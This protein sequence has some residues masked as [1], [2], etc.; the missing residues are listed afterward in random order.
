MRRDIIVSGVIAV[1][2]HGLIFSLPLTMARNNYIGA[3]HHKSLS[4]S[5]IY[6]RKAVAALPSVQ[7]PQV[8]SK[9]SSE[10]ES[11]TSE[12]QIVIKK[13]KVTHKK[14]FILKEMRVE[15]G[16]L[17]EA[18]QPEPAPSQIPKDRGK[19]IESTLPVKTASAGGHIPTTGQGGIE[20]TWENR[21]TQDSIVYARPRYKENP[22]P[23]YPRLA[24]TRGYQGRALLRV[25]VMENGNPGRIEIEESS[26]FEVLDAAALRSVKGWTFVPGTINGKGTKQ[27]IRVPIRFVLK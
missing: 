18:I 26:G 2:I 10:S 3:H 14:P 9:P 5:V 12:R 8:S 17:E 1:A 6:P 20:T 24:R 4:M 22:L 23:D 13:Q 19:R 21:I 11:R 15:Q 7:T 16:S 27:W 25:E